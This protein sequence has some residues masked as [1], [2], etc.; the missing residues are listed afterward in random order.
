MIPA[1]Y[2]WIMRNT[3]DR[4]LAEQLALELDIPEEI[5]GLLIERGITDVQ[6]A[7]K[8]F[9]PDTA[10]MHDPYL[11][12]EM[13]RA[14]A[15]ID[16]AVNAREIITIYGDYDADGMTATSIL[17]LYFTSIGVNVQYYLP[18]RMKEGYGLNKKAVRKIAAGG[19][20]LMVTVDTGISGMDCCRLAHELGM[21]IV[22][23]DHHECP[24]ELPEADTVVDAK[25]KDETYPYRYLAGCGVALKLVQALSERRGDSIDLNRYLEIAAIGTIADVVPLTGENRI[26]TSAGLKIIRNT[27]NIG[28]RKLMEV[29][30]YHFDKKIGADYIG[31]GAG[32]RLNAAGRLGSARRGV[33]LLTADSALKAAALAAELDRENQER[34]NIEQLILDEAVQNLENAGNPASQYFL[35]AAGE[36][37]HKGVVGIVSSRV[38]DLYY[39]PNVVLSIEGDTATGS[40]RSIDGLNLYEALL[41]CSDLLIKFGGHAAA[42]GLTLYTKDIPEFTRRINEYT[43]EHTD[44]Q[45]MV[46]TLTA[47]VAVRPSDI[48]V[49]MIRNAEKFE[50]TGAEMPQPYFVTA[51]V[52]REISRIG[53]DRETIRIKLYDGVDELTAVGFRCGDY[54]YYYQP[55]SRVSVI[56]YVQVDEFAGLEKP[57][58]MIQDLHPAEQLEAPA[59]AQAFGLRF[60]TDGFAKCS[61]EYCRKYGKLKKKDCNDIY[62]RLVTVSV[63]QKSPGE[64]RFL[65]DDDEVG[66]RMLMV[67]KVFEELG[68]LEIASN[69]FYFSYKLIQGRTAKLIDSDW[70]R[71]FFEN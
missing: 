27:E 54:S 44:A 29:S 62:R 64:G 69:G 60:L 36:G 38:R 40:G 70:Y 6:Q 30:G 7:Q 66:C 67:C 11:M 15:L 50:P 32:P 3:Y 2:R 37:W 53:K 8:F 59:C 9:E 51:G 31:F 55:G 46:P 39:R 57:Q 68:L 33:E 26:I 45:M 4:S 52:I 61:S 19:T 48:T 12:K 1:S 43:R 65:V 28:V 56:G 22:V 23:T 16:E 17:L 47:E 35:V 20:K 14:A 41:S 5:A 71:R 58:L 42:A 18:D 21:K 24:A 49:G 25:R 34:K 13:D 63:Q 10:D